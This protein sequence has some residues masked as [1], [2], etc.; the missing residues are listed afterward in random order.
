MKKLGKVLIMAGGT[1]GHVFPALAIAK[2]F[3]Q[4]G[5][6]VEWM[7]TANGLEARIVPA[8]KIPLHIIS[9]AGIR[10]KGLKSFLLA[11]FRIIIAIFQSIRIIRQVKPNVI[12]G[13]GGFVSGPGGIASWL[14]CKPL[15]IHEQNA[16]IGTTNRWLAL[17]AKMKLEGFPGAFPPQ[18]NTLTIGNPVREEILHL[19][20]PEERF[21]TLRPK[22]HLLILGGSLGA[23]AFN[24]LVPEA[25]A[26]MPLLERPMVFH[27]TG[28]KQAEETLK[29]YASLGV[30]ATVVPFIAKMHEA[31]AWADLV[32]CRAGALTIAELCAVGLGAILVPF[33]YAIDDHQTANANYL[34]DHG[35][36]YLIPQSD[37]TADK[38]VA[39]LQYLALHPEDRLKM[40]LASYRLRRVDVTDKVLRVCE[41]MS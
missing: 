16:R 33:P 5:I 35:A 1:G 29:L 6:A 41:E 26:K 11:P 3:Q 12:I 37:F 18:K 22:V 34:A 2:R 20:A 30:Q 25:I 21:K 8:A 17:I 23:Q 7:G 24:Q 38:L 36:G 31:Y 32:L 9:I 40:A 13:M 19:P 27:Q 39:I 4:A 10:G 14:L 15:I 28:E